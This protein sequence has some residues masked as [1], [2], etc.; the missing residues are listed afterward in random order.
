MRVLVVGGVT[1]D[2]IAKIDVPI[3]SGVSGRKLA[4]SAMLRCVGGGG[5]NAAA[6]FRK[7]GLG[8][9]LLA[10]IGDDES[11][12]EVNRWAHTRQIA[13]LGAPVARATGM[14]QIVVDSAGDTLTVAERGANQL[15]DLAALPNSLQGEYHAVYVS[16]IPE[17][18]AQQLAS[19][20]APLAQKG[21][22]IAINPARHL[23]THGA[24]ALMRLATLS[25]LLCLN[26]DE[27]NVLAA[28]LSAGRTLYE[29]DAELLCRDLTA[30]GFTRVV[31]TD[32]ARGATLLKDG[33]P[34]QQPAP[35]VSPMSTLGAGDA[36]HAT[37][38]GEML[39]GAET[40]RA[41]RH[42]SAQA[43]AVVA[44]LDAQSGL[45]DRTAVALRARAL[46]QGAWP[47]PA[48]TI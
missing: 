38:F 3:A 33:V 20:L 1:I 4:A 5:A 30:H 26:L 11:G 18:A 17:S 10:A 24:T 14:A 46:F 47:V 23:L 34:F 43:A 8:V 39:A 19:V 32:G 48:M 2:Q 37:L 7:L 42:A 29:S 36:F 44:A 13:L 21:L 41:L 9:S 12:R 45:L 16:S 28:S 27:A 15:L 35:H 22:K 40:V 6:C 31:I 25:P